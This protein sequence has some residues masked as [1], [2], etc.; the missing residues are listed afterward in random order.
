MN[1]G[2]VRVLGTGAMACWLGGLLAEAGD[3]VTLVGTWPEAL[4]RLRS[5]G[6]AWRGAGRAFRAR[7]RAR[8]VDGP[9]DTADVAIV[10]VKAHQTDLVAPHAFRALTDAAPVLSLQN[11][12]GPREALVAAAPSEAGRVAVGV[13]TVGARLLGPGE[14]DVSGDARVVI[15]R[16]PTLGAL[17]ARLRHAGVDTTEADDIRPHVWR[18]LVA[19]CAI[20]ALTALHAV[21]NGALLTR[22]DLRAPFE[23]AAREAGAVA[24]ALGL[25]LGADPVNLARAVAAATAANRSSMLQDLERGVPT[26]VDALH[27]AVVREA[28]RLG[29][30]APTLEAQW[31]AVLRRSPDR[32]QGAA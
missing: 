5:G 25:E 15:E 30:E 31:Q 10:L 18:K 3:D 22:D 12:L 14:V 26:E 4:E 11:G 29:L 21:P 1:A 32:R 9:L 23:S 2:R 7:V 28:R 27:G 24:R 17:V 6:I 16:R 13:A 20:N 19:N 8:R